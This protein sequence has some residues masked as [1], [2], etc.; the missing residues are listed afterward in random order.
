M[1]TLFANARVVTMDGPVLSDAFVAVEGQKILSVSADRPQGTFDRVVDC[2]GKVLMPGLVNAHTHVPM[3]LLRGYGK[4]DLQTWLNDYIFPAEAKL[5]GRAVRAGTGLA[6][7]ELIAAGVTSFADMYY[8]CDEIIEETVAAGLSANISRGTTCFAPLDDPASYP[9]CAEARELIDRWHGY[10]DGQIKIDLS[11]HG[12]YTSFL[13]PKLWDYLARLAA[14]HHLGMQV[15]LSETKSEREECLARHGKTPFQVLDSHGVFPFGGLAA[16]CV[17]CSDE[18]FA[19]MAKRG[20]AAVH[21]PVSNL[22]L[23]SGVARVPAMLRAGVNVCLGTDGVS[24]NNNHDLF[25]EIK[26]AAILHNGLARDPEAVSP[27]Q[28]LEMATSAGAKALGRKAG[29]VV[30]GYDADLILLDFDHVSL[31]PC[32]DVV[33]NLVYSARGS[34]VVLNMARG[35]IIYENGTYYT[36]DLDRI[37]AEVAGY[38]LPKLFG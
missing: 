20:V 35:N 3:T 32:H 33:A 29:K 22:K 12:E 2:T 31:T 15:H 7:A 4:G 11:I 19:L 8:F 38:A 28:A 6:L 14:D 24:S 18:D 34:D 26:L 23:G 5:D 17:W 13:A 1:R 30:P 10:G 21:N 37:R 27:L 16:H 36:L 9:A 25:E